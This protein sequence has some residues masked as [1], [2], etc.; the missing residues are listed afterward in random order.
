MLP[1]ESH[2]LEMLLELLDCVIQT[3]EDVE[4]LEQ[5]V[6][7]LA[8]HGKLTSQDPNDE[9]ASVLLNRLAAE[10]ARLIKQ[11]EIRKRGKPKPLSATELTSTL[12]ETWEWTRLGA[13]A[14]DIHYG[15]TASAEH[16]IRDIRFLR[17][18]DIQDNQVDWDT[19]PGCIIEEEKISKYELERDDILIART[20]GTVGK[21]YLVNQPPVRAVFAS[22]LIRIIPPLE[23]NARFLKFFLE[24]PSYWEQLI[25]QSKGTGQ[26]NVNATSLGNLVVPIPPLEEQKRI[27][28]KVDELFAQTRRLKAQLAQTAESRTTLQKAAVRRLALAETPAQR[29]DAWHLI[30]GH[31]DTLYDAPAHVD[32]LKETILQLAVQGKLVPQGLEEEPAAVLLER[33]GQER[34]WLVDVGEIR[35]QKKSQPIPAEKMPA[36]PRTWSWVRL[37]D[38]L[39]NIQA[40]KSPQARKRPADEGEYGVLK[41]SAVSWGRFQPREN[42]ALFPG[43]SVDGVPSVRANDLLI[44]RA[45][46]VELVG[47]VVLAENDYPNLL[48]SDKT[49][50]L[51]FVS[52]SIYKPFMLLAL[53]APWVRDVFEDRA[54]GT[55]SSMRNISQAKIRLA[56]I[57]MP[58]LQEQ[59][60]IVAKTDRLLAL[61]DRLTEHVTAAHTIR[62]R[63]LEALL[64]GAT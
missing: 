37:G 14:L 60:R 61:C 50:R 45:N 8:M 31:F 3:P 6:G 26:P 12:P 24:S 55:S 9:P 25:A 5:A 53:Q 36:I 13:I 11:G 44:S 64:A 62:E 4:K 1:E 19:V 17:I 15:Y 10:K 54:T 29:S 42:K 32:D 18:T 22:Y 23:I 7:Q 20:G 49:L 47:S 40:G 63:L 34:E 41:V 56:P 28:A 51:D 39:S 35:K 46:T 21:S 43:T 38:L 52:E 2:G 16:D 57:A 27:V 59:K 33:I 58:P 30:A 48:L